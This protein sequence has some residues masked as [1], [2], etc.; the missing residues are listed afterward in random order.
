MNKDTKEGFEDS[1]TDYWFLRKNGINAKTTL[2]MLT[3]A[4]QDKKGVGG[5]TK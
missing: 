2:R 1:N 5:E 3:I 4:Y